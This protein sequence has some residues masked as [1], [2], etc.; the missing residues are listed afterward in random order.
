MNG[1]IGTILSSKYIPSNSQSVSIYYHN[2]NDLD[3]VS[4]NMLNVDIN[5]NITIVSDGLNPNGIQ[6]GNNNLYHI[7]GSFRVQ[8]KN[9]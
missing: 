9:K 7:Y 1:I 5:G 4:Q 6:V 3:N 2:N 8:P